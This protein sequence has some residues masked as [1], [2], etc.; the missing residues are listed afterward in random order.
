MNKSIVRAEAFY[1]IRTPGT[2][3]VDDKGQ[4]V[5]I[6]QNKVYSVFLEVKGQVPEWTRAWADEKF[7]NIIALP[8]KEKNTVIGSIKENDQQVVMAA[9][10]GNTLLQLELSPNELFQKSPE[11]LKPGEVLL[12]G[13]WQGKPF[14]HKVQKVVELA[15][16]MYQ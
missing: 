2:I 15:S 1:T 9:S 16:P 11:V 14:Y 5:P 12:E 3:A 4:P 13:K 6:Q 10:N 7:F 8:L